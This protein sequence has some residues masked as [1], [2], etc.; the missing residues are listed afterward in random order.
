MPKAC[1]YVN[2]LMMRKAASCCPQNFSLFLSDHVMITYACERHQGG[3]Q[4]CLN[5]VNTR[6]STLFPIMLIIHGSMMSNVNKHLMKAAVY[7]DSWSK[8]M[9]SF[10]KTVGLT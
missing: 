4:Q 5:E 1:E 7:V 2:P 9:E 10:P 8:M 6:T 3:M